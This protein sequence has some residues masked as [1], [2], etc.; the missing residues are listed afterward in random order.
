[1]N[2]KAMAIL[3][4]VFLFLFTAISSVEAVP[5]QARDGAHGGSGHGQTG[6]IL[7][8]L[9]KLDLTPAQEKEVASILR[10]HREEIGDGATGMAEARMAFRDTM[11][12]EEYSD[13]A[14]R[15]AAQGLGEQEEQFAVLIAQIMNEVRSVLTPAQKERMKKIRE[16]RAAKMKN[17]A[18]S[19]LSAL[20]KW[21][22]EH[23]E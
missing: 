6:D 3:L 23:G 15:Q 19:K 9:N 14:V 16:R 17:S 7:K 4:S 21:I 12:A 10:K 22:A 2:M 1:M 13:A 11:M 18:E 8:I 5:R 20:D